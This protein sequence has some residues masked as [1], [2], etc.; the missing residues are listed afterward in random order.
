LFNFEPVEKNLTGEI[1]RKLLLLFVSFF[2]YLNIYPQSADSLFNTF[3][4]NFQKKYFSVGL[5]LQTTGDYQDERLSGKNGFNLQNVRL[6]IYGEFDEGFGYFFQTN[7][8]NTK[9]VLDAYIYHKFS[10][11]LRVDIGQ[12]RVPYSYEYLTSATALDFVYRSQAANSLSPKRQIG[13]TLR[14]NLTGELNLAAGIYNGNGTNTANDNNFFMYVSR[15]A[16]SPKLA[17]GKLTAA[18]STAYSKDESE[19]GRLNRLMFGGDI[20]FE[21]QYLILGSEFSQQELEDPADIMEKTNGYHIT[22]G[23]KINKY[24]QVLGRYDVLNFEGDDPDNKLII[25]GLNFIQ[26]D[27]ARF[28]FNYVVNADDSKIEHNQVLLSAQAA[29]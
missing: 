7:F 28:Q 11:L 15:L 19:N 23:Y 8:V 6:K 5:Q 14:S 4:N 20:R 21:N 12:Y 9:P 1:V 16:Y 29:F 13:V 3:K 22:A 17:G 2:S 10:D 25:A 27:I 26:T 18:A 24:F